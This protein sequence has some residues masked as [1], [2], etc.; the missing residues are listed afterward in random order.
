MPEI[1]CPS[2]GKEVCR[3]GWAE[4]VVEVDIRE[5]LRRLIGAPLVMSDGRFLDCGSCEL[6]GYGGESEGGKELLNGGE[7]I[8]NVSIVCD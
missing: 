3:R 4:R 6:D 8:L 5:G 1:P 2:G 7:A